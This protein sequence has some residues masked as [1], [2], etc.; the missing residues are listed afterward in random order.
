MSAADLLTQLATL[1]VTLTAPAADRLVYRAPRGVLTPDLLQAMREAKA[2][3]CALLR[4]PAPVC[5]AD[6]RVWVTGKIPSSSMLTTPLPEPI[7]HD[8]PSPPQTSLGRP[9]TVKGCKPTDLFP[10]G[11][12]AS[13]YY[14]PSGVCVQCYARL[15]KRTSEKGFS[16]GV[17]SQQR[18]FDW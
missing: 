15:D 6:Y 5:A 16:H 9:C 18:L 7:Y 10:T 3:L 12:P 8:G 11:Q 2:A 14:R 17:Q 4:P 13:R 1:G